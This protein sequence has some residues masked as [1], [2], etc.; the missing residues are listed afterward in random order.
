MSVLILAPI[1]ALIVAGLMIPNLTKSHKQRQ[2]RCT[3]VHEAGHAVVS[4]MLG[5]RFKTI[6]V[7]TGNGDSPGHVEGYEEDFLSCS[8]ADQLD[9]IRIA[10]AG[11][12]AS[13]MEFAGN[14]AD[15]GFADNLI[16]EKILKE[17]PGLFGAKS[18]EEF[19]W[20]TKNEVRLLLAG[21]ISEVNI[22][23]NA[24]L[25]NGSFTEAEV[26]DIVSISV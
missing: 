6:S 10:L 26:R 24:L 1:L 13:D 5:R 7:E 21:K 25:L 17:N 14:H 19:I 15:D 20:Q 11:V 18:R 23:A 3:A 8:P 12:I 2:K 22:L 4:L 16:I 9:T